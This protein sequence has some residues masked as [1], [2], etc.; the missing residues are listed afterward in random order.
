MAKHMPLEVQLEKWTERTDACWN[1]TGGLGARGYGR[2]QRQGKIYQAHRAMYELANG[3]IPAGMVIDHM[4]HNRKCVR[5]DHLQAVTNKQNLENYTGLNRNNTSGVRGV[6]WHDLTKTWMAYAN[7]QGKRYIG[8]RFK[9]IEEAA[10]AVV[11]LR[12]RL[13]TNNLPDRV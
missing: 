2:I 4:C 9:T 10:I 11:E 6:Y 8:G 1:W 5:P 13:H 7:H 3:P 12:N